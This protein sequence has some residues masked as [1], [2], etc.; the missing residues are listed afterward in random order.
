[1]AKER[2]IRVRKPLALSYKEGKFV[3]GKMK[4][5]RTKY[6]PHFR[7]VPDDGK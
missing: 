3:K 5:V 4:R 1:M 6:W 2:K 7:Y